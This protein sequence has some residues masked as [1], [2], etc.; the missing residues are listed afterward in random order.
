MI[1]GMI[2]ASR[3]ALKEE[4]RMD[5][6]SS[7]LANSNT[8]GFK[9]DRVSFQQMLKKAEESGAVPTS[10]DIK[11]DLE[12]G[13]MRNT[14]NNLDVAIKGKGFFKVLTPEGVRYTRK[15]N[16]DLDGQGN[17][18]TQ[19]GYSVLGKGGTINIQGK[20]IEIGTDGM[21]LVDGVQSGQLDVVD[22]SEYNS[23]V[24]TGGSLF[25]NDSADEIGL[26]PGTTIG[27]GFLELSNVNVAEEMVNMIHSL[28]AFE[29]YQK[30]MKAID[31]LNNQAINQVGRLR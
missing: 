29:S 17:L 5:I 23:L 4:I 19:N 22:F 27:Q 6:I 10:V 26:E 9:K 30:S 24:K 8:V 31:E 18:I 15:G 2:E 3:G 14:G 16:F 7:N 1:N 25:R 13:D 12:Q 20:V 11:V 28:R 21:I